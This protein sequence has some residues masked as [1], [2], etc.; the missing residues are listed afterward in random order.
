[1]IRTKTHRSMELNREESPETNLQLFG[2]FTTKEAK[3]TQWEKRT[4][5]L[6]NSVEKLDTLMQKRETRPLSDTIQAM[7]S[8]WIKDPKP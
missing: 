6:I 2:Q 5:S 8:K 4:A 7:N 3:K 1:M